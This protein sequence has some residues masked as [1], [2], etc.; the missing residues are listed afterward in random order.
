MNNKHIYL[1]MQER[2]HTQ[3]FTGRAA[4]NLSDS[5]AFDVPLSSSVFSTVS[6]WVTFILVIYDA[7][8]GKVK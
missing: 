8:F 2:V 6:H 4:V 1:H 3:T 5:R 7:V